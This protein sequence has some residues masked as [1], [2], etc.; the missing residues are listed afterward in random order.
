MRNKMAIAT[1]GGGATF[2][3]VA[4]LALSTALA[5]DPSQGGR[6]AALTLGFSDS[7]EQRQAEPERREGADAVLEAPALE[8]W[9]DPGLLGAPQADRPSWARG[10]D[11]LLAVADDFNAPIFVRTGRDPWGLGM[12]RRGGVL[13]V[14]AEVRGRGCA[15]GHWYELASGGFVCSA[16]G[17]QVASNASPPDNAPRTADITKPLPYRYAKLVGEEP[18]VRYSRIPTSQEQ[19]LAEAGKLDELPDELGAHQMEG[20]YFLA[21]DGRETH[22]G[23]D[24][25]RTLRGQYVL[26]KDIELIETPQ[27]HGE[28]LDGEGR[29]LPLAFVH[30]EDAALYEV[31]NGKP[32]KAG[33]AEKHARIFVDREVKH[34]GKL[35]YV[36]AEGRALSAATVRLVEKVDRPADVAAGDKWVH[37][38]LAEQAITAYQGDTPI[39]ATLVSS[40]KSGHDTP[41]GN[42]HVRHKYISITMSGDDPVDGYYEVEEVPWTMYYYGSYALH[43]AYW[44]NNFGNVKSHGCTNIAPADARWLYAWSSPDVPKGWHGRRELGTYVH[45]SRAPKNPENRNPG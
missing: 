4:A 31:E 37:V 16:R 10:G 33:K 32:V 29:S 1:V 11:T 14:K 18:P 39:F 24:F 42:Y 13:Q 35:Y 25:Y 6:V 36:D 27:M 40:G 12:M 5:D 26:Q 20:D 19:A 7:A 41:D 15:G 8:G 34:D 45:I 21:L 2:G 23:R 17:F 22:G 9:M 3:A 30:V 38:D 28:H 44:H 43:G